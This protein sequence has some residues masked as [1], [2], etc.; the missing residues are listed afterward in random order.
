MYEMYLDDFFWRR[1]ESKN[2]V[3]EF[4]RIMGLFVL[5]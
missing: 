3:K 5:V 4:L 2:F 1:F